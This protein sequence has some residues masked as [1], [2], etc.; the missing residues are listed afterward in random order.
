[1]T[2]FLFLSDSDKFLGWEYNSLFIGSADSHTD[3]RFIVLLSEVNI[4]LD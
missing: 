1:M 4:Y 3:D 2:V